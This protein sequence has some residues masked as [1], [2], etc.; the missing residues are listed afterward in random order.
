[1]RGGAAIQWMFRTQKCTTLSSSE[2]EYVAMVEGFKEARFLRS[3]WSFS[4]PFFGT[5]ASGFLRT[6]TVRFTWGVDAVANSNSKHIDAR[7]HFLR[8][9][10]EKGEFRSS[11][12]QSKCQHAEFLTK[13]LS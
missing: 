13:P 5:R 7:H 9:L 4:C 2:G 11:Q 12:L 3:V 8:E 1:M 10:A 6:T